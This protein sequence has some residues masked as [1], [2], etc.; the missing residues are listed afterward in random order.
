[1]TESKTV[2]ISEPEIVLANVQAVTPEYNEE[3]HTI[4]VLTPLIPADDTWF[5]ATLIYDLLRHGV[6]WSTVKS[7]YS[8]AKRNPRKNIVAYVRERGRKVYDELSCCAGVRTTYKF[9]PAPLNDGL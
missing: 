4:R 7:R 3:G 2:R 6:A 1:M 8:L 9:L 5:Q